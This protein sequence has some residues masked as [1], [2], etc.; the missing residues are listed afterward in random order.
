MMSDLVL[1]DES[2]RVMGACFE[3]YKR[4]GCGFLESVYQECLAIEFEEQSIP[5][6]AHPKQS[7]TYRGKTLDAYFIPDFICYDQI[8]V[9]IKAVSKIVDE[10]RS[11]VINYLSAAQLPLGLIIN[12]GHQPRVEHERIA[13]TK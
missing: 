11:Q 1:P 3:V 2:Y 10:Y 12:F 8:I 6:Q 5:F 9:E 4:M 13:Y 7:L